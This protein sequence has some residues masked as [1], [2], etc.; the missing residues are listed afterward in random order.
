MKNISI[1]LFLI[2]I[3]SLFTFTLFH[4]K[5]K[6]IH[7]SEITLCNDKNQ[8]ATLDEMVTYYLNHRHEK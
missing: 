6:D 1:V 3:F 5:P 7:S 8:C 2:I 4:I